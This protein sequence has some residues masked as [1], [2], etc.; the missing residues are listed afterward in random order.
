[1]HVSKAPF[2]K[3]WYIFG[4]ISKSHQLQCI[5]H[6]HSKHKCTQHLLLS[7]CPVIDLTPTCC[8]FCSLSTINPITKRS[9]SLPCLQSILTSQ[10]ITVS[11]TLFICLIL[12]SCLLNF[13]FAIY[14]SFSASYF[15]NI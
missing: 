4:C 2:R 1:M 12:F 15:G 3:V 5:L 10:Q 8:T 14:F 11:L 13:S 6:I 9:V 7:L